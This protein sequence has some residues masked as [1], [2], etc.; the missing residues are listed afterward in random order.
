[1][2]LKNDYGRVLSWNTPRTQKYEACIGILI[3]LI[4][5]EKE[6][7]LKIQK[8][9]GGGGREAGKKDMESEKLKKRIQER[10]GKEI[11]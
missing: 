11:N 8:T 3:F 1:V 7:Y 6:I 4:I 9:R 2:N 5:S 10:K